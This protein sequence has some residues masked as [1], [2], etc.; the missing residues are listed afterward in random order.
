MA[1]PSYAPASI[2]SS[3]S[4]KLSATASRPPSPS[5]SP[6]LSLTSR[7]PSIE[8]GEK[9]SCFQ[10]PPW[11]F[12]SPCPSVVQ[13]THRSYAYT[14]RVQINSDRCN[15]VLIGQGLSQCASLSPLLSLL[16]TN[17]LRA[18]VSETTKMI[19]LFQT[20]KCPIHFI[21]RWLSSSRETKRWHR[22]SG[23]RWNVLP[24]PQP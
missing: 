17:D 14:A 24:T 2:K 8:L 3:E 6:R 5:A 16:D 15:S 11:A 4:L 1:S 7:K 18:V 22:N 10:R 13:H 19:L 9:N 23:N 12:R 21:H 20:P